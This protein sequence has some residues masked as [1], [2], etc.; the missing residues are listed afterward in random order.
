MT[1]AQLAK[2]PETDVFSEGFDDGF[3]ALTPSAPAPRPDA[4][5]D[6]FGSAQIKANVVEKCDKCRGAGQFVSWSGRV[7]GQCFVCQGKGTRVFRLAKADREKA[8]AKRETAKLSKAQ[9]ALEAFQAAH[10]D[11]WA[12]MDGSTFEFAVS[13]RAALEKYGH[14]TEPQLAAAKRSVV[15]LAEAKAQRAA[16][17]E[18]APIIDLTKIMAAFE[19]AKQNG[20]A[21]PKVR[22]AGLQIN[23]AGERSKYPGSLSVK[24]DGVWIGRIASGKFVR[25]RD[26]TDEIERRV[27]ETCA[28]PRAAAIAYGVQTGSCSCCGRELTN[29]ESVE[30]GIGPICAAK[31]GWA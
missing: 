9:K 19:S 16:A 31:Y 28:D 27:I 12:W 7:V 18:A 15:K 2:K 17:I 6:N 30:L 8:K 13:L 10:P 14:L 29:K 25:G 26:C 21:F 20:L 22:F 1:S 3:D 23:I 24:A 11:V 5:K 4:P